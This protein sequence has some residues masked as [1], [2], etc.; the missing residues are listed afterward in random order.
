MT[1]QDASKDNAHRRTKYRRRQYLIDPAAQWKYAATIM[2]AVFMISALLSILLY[3]ILH[4]QAR[5]RMLHPATYT[6]RVAQIIVVFSLGYAVV[7][8]MGLGLWSIIA[9]HRLCGPMFVMK[10]YLSELANG[11][12]PCP[13]PL[14]KKDEF[15][16][17]YAVFTRATESLRDSRNA[18][19]ATLEEAMAVAS[20]ASRGA[21]PARKQA[22]DTIV[23]QLERLRDTARYAIGGADAPVPAQHKTAVEPAADVPVGVAL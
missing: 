2:L 20:S 7:N 23:G 3:G 14:R 19:I 10:R 17:L 18:E 9:T 5:E 6:A 15:K 21:D 4:G 22:L 1:S 8:A 12:I 11:R 13:R 16:D